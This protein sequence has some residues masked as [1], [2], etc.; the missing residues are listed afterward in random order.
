MKAIKTT[1]KGPTNVRGSRIVATDGDGNRITLPWDHSINGEKNHA[2]AAIALCAKMQW[3]GKL[4]EGSLR[5]GHVFVFIDADSTY[6][7]SA[8]V[9]S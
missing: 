4:A 3:S 9:K 6:I 7:V 8:E 2:R 1:Y 5:D